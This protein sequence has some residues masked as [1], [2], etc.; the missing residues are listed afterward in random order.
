MIFFSSLAE[1]DSAEKKEEEAAKHTQV[2]N[3]MVAKA[4]D[5][6]DLNQEGK[7]TVAQVIGF[8]IS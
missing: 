1:D 3:E 2:V 6:C 5:E 8:L 4:F 7:L